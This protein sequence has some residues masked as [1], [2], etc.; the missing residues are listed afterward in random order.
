MFPVIYYGFKNRNGWGSPQ[1]L[2]EE[3]SLL[4][5][6]QPHMA[7]CSPA[8]CSG[9]PTSALLK[10]A[11][12]SSTYYYSSGP[13]SAARETAKGQGPCYKWQ[14]KIQT[15]DHHCNNQDTVKK[16]ENFKAINALLLRTHHTPEAVTQY[17]LSWNSE[18]CCLLPFL[19]DTVTL[20]S[21]VQN[22]GC[23]LE[24][25]G[26]PALC[27]ARLCQHSHSSTWL[28][29]HRALQLHLED[30]ARN[31]LQQGEHSLIFVLVHSR[32]NSLPLL[33]QISEVF[34]TAVPDCVLSIKS[35]TLTLNCSPQELNECVT[36][37]CTREWEWAGNRGASLLCN[38]S[39]TG[40]VQHKYNCTSSSL[41]TDAITRPSLKLAHSL[42]YQ[43]S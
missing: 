39:M 26:D 4:A 23:S 28:L 34:S 7:Q 13:Y 18:Q 29:Q 16:M 2:T 27:A 6:T 32:P 5:K 8:G 36:T 20:Q 30:A 38:W 42:I 17:S 10:L 15:Q 14:Q 12:R 1:A 33:L 11:E 19:G 43:W 22:P 40:T 24:V 41:C 3:V 21:G 35:N 25:R 31:H 9:T 37:A